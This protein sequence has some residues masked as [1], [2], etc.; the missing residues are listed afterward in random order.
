[1]GLVLV[2]GLVRSGRVLRGMSARLPARGRGCFAGVGGGGVSSRLARC[3]A[4]SSGASDVL[5]TAAASPESSRATTPPGATQ[6]DHRKPSAKPPAVPNAQPAI[7]FDGMRSNGLHRTL[8]PAIRCPER[9]TG[10]GATTGCDQGRAPIVSFSSRRP[11]RPTGEGAR[12]AA[13]KV[14]RRAPLSAERPISQSAGGVAPNR[15]AANLARVRHDGGACWLLSYWTSARK[16]RL[17]PR[18]VQL[19]RRARGL[20]GRRSEG[21]PFVGPEP[22]GGW[23]LHEGSYDG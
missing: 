7:A 16:N 14:L 6:P 22:A 13:S 8:P 9:P 4:S 1:M 23:V 18:R 10:E 21:A 17:N 2:L 11:A 19:G 15:L 20:P 3:R 5:P 12:R